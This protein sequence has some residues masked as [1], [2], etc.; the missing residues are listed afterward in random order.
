[1]IKHMFAPEP[2]TSRFS[3][4]FPV[5]LTLRPGQ[6]RAYSEDTRAMPDAAARL[7]RRYAELRVP[8]QII[9]GSEDKIVDVDRHSRRLSREISHSRLTVVS[10]AGHMFHHTSPSHLTRLIDDALKAEHMPA[11]A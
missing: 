1:M 4:Q 7:S 8:T 9:C 3:K 6:I 10:G 5:P 11:A 2:I